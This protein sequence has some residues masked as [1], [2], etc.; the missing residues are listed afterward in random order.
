MTFLENF[1]NFRFF[2]HFLKT[3]FFT[4]ISSPTT[5]KNIFLF[6]LKISI[7]IY[8]NGGG[9][10]SQ[11]SV[12]LFLSRCFGHLKKISGQ[13]KFDFLAKKVLF[14]LRFAQKLARGVLRDC[15]NFTS[16][17]SPKRGIWK[18]KKI[19]F[20]ST[21]DRYYGVHPV[22]MGR[23]THDQ[24]GTK[25]HVMHSQCE[26]RMFLW[27]FAFINEIAEIARFAGN[28]SDFVNKCLRR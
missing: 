14:G 15:R 25:S 24:K 6:W 5:Q 3:K 18:N 26:I 21:L 23:T 16:Y 20:W 11:I 13:K 2:C 22:K 17:F 28:Y 8:Y 12:W 19:F 10:F 7:C 27:F 4:K 1:E 9:C